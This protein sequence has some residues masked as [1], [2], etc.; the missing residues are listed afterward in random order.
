[1]IDEQNTP[2]PF[3]PGESP[4]QPPVPP[5]PPYG[6]MEP[7]APTPVWNLGLTFV[8]GAIIFIVFALIQSAVFI[9]CAVPVLSAKH[10][11]GYNFLE[12]V[13]NDQSELMALQTHGDIISWVAIVSGILTTGIIWIF[14]KAKK[15]LSFKEY[16]AFKTP[17]GKQVVLWLGIALGFFLFLELIATTSDGFSTSFMS[18]VYSTT[19]NLLPLYLGVGVIGPI[20]EE[21][22]FR[23]FLF[24][25]IERGIKNENSGQWAVLITSIIFTIIHTQYDWQV[26]M[27]LFPLGLM[28]GYSRLYSKSLWVPIILHMANNIASIALTGLAEA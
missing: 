10:P 1:M 27:L 20:F 19:S 21:I 15:G 11:S 12:M 4:P 5:R 26:L 16:L 25:G 9:I 28:L 13:A 7:P 17:A 24:A 22:F 2:A 8:F 14:I 6:A 23:G 18:D 3:N